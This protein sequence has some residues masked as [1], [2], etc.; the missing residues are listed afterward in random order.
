[1]FLIN[2][3]DPKSIDDLITSTF[4]KIIDSTKRFSFDYVMLLIAN[5]YNSKS[6]KAEKVIPTII[7]KANEFSRLNGLFYIDI[8]FNKQNNHDI[9]NKVLKVRLNQSF[10]QYT[11][12][13]IDTQHHLS[14][15]IIYF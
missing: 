14:K 6:H 2:L 5:S 11:E 4:P 3:N 13:Y 1:M 12:F 9:I 7:Q 8:D 10:N 15:V